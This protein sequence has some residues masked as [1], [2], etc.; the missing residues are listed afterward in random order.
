MGTC[1]RWPPATSPVRAMIVTL[2]SSVDLIL[3]SLIGPPA[4]YRAKYF[5]TG[6]N[7]LSAEPWSWRRLN[8]A[9]PIHLL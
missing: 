6:S 3:L 9:D 5:K 4:R 2:P 1:L 8:E 7:R